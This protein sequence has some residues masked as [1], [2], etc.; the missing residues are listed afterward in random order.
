MHSCIMPR[1]TASLSDA[2][3]D[4][5]E[6]AADDL[7]ESMAEIVR[8]L[9]DALRVGDVQH[10]ALHSAAQHDAHRDV[11]QRLDELA[12]RVSALEAADGSGGLNQQ[13]DSGDAVLVNDRGA[14]PMSAGEPQG[15]GDEDMLARV[16]E[17]GWDGQGGARNDERERA[18]ASAASLL[19]E[20]GMVAPIVLRRHVLDEFDVGLQESSVQRLL[21]DN[22]SKLDEIETRD[23]GQLYEWT[24][25]K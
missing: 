3:Y 5:L 2:Q 18:V 7:D 9:V 23:G 19:R 10:D 21:S 6:S 4:A 20:R 1:V 14:G 8:R 22:L 17:I 16:R 24:G 25:E 12:E 11:Q 15:S 13:A